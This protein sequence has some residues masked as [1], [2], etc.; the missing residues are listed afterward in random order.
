MF[1]FT[2]RGRDLVQNFIGQEEGDN[3]GDTYEEIEPPTHIP[4]AY[5]TRLQSLLIYDIQNISNLELIIMCVLKWDSNLLRL[6]C[7]YQFS[8]QCSHLS[9]H[10]I[11]YQLVL[12]V[13]SP[14]D[15]DKTLF[16]HT[17][18]FQIHHWTGPASNVSER[19]T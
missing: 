4:I 1:I 6:H 3:Y 9:L 11:A 2:H 16:Q 19:L 8:I 10:L 14:V 5:S 18:P 7:L 13:M 12:T 17:Q 15:I